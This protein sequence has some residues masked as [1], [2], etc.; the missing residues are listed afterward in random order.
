MSELEAQPK[1][2]TVLLLVTSSDHHVRILEQVGGNDLAAMIIRR[3]KEQNEEVDLVRKNE[4]LMDPRGT[5]AFRVDIDL[6]KRI[7]G[8]LDIDLDPDNDIRETDHINLIINS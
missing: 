2:K 4:D 8:F 5:D 1:N 7:T 3:H 6:F